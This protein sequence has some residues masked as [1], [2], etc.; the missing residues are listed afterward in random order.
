M[1]TEYKLSYTASEI[2]RKLA[3]VDETKSSLENDYYTSTEIDTKINEVNTSLEAKA[4]LVDGKIPTSQLPDDIGGDVAW[5][6]IQNKPFGEGGMVTVEF[7]S[8]ISESTV[9]SSQ[10]LEALGGLAFNYVKVGSQFDST[11]EI[12]GAPISATANGQTH[13]FTVDSSHL[14][15]IENGFAVI[16]MGESVF[17]PACLNVTS[18]GTLTLPLADAF[19]EDLVFNTTETGLYFVYIDG[20]GQ[21]N[22][23]AR[24]EVK[25]ID[26]KFIPDTIARKSDI[27]TIDLSGKADLVN[28]KVP[29]EQLPDDIGGGVSSWND[30][31]DKP[32]YEEGVSITVP[33]DVSGL[34][35][36]GSQ[37][38][39]ALGGTS[40]SFIKVNDALSTSEETYGALI[41]V[42]NDGGILEFIVDDSYVNN[43]DNGFALISFDN[44]FYPLA[45]NVN[46]VGTTVLSTADMLGEDM[47]FN[48]TETGFYVLYIEG[49]GNV[50]SYSNG[51]FKQLDEK[52]I[53][54]IFVKSA[55]MGT[56][57]GVATLD[58]DGKVP[59]SQLPDNIGSGS[60]GG[61]GVTSWNDLEDKPFGED[62]ITIELPTD[63]SESSTVSTQGLS[64]LGGIAFTY[65]KVRS[66]FNSADEVIG[67]EV[68]ATIS[69]APLDFAVD[70]SHIADADN[71]FAILYSD[72]DNG[73]ILPACINVTSVGVLTIPAVEIFGE[74]LIIDVTNEG[75]EGLYF[76][77]VEGMGQTNSI[78]ASTVNKIDIKYLPSNIGGG[79]TEVTWDDIKNKP[80]G[81]TGWSIEWDGNPDNSLGSYFLEAAGVT[82]Y[83][84]GNEAKTKEEVVGTTCKWVSDDAESECIITIDD[85]I[86]TDSENCFVLLSEDIGGLFAIVLA[87]GTYDFMGMSLV[88]STGVWAIK[89]DGYTSTYIGGSEIK[90]IDKKY[91]PDDI[92]ASVSLT[93]DEVPTEGSQNPV[94]SMGIYSAISALEGKITSTFCYKGTVDNYSDLPSSN[95]TVGDV[96]NIANADEANGVNAGD[97]A[98]W[99]GSSWDILAGVIDLSDYY[100]KTEI[101]SM[102][103]NGNINLTN[104]YTKAETDSL[105]ANAN[106]GAGGGGNVDLS[107]YYTK[108]ETD[109]SLALK[110][111]LVDGKVPLEQLPEDIGSGGNIVDC[112]TYS[113]GSFMSSDPIMI[114]NYHKV[115]NTITADYQIDWNI[116]VYDIDTN[117][118]LFTFTSP[119][120]ITSNDNIVINIAT[121]FNGTTYNDY[122]SDLS[123]ELQDTKGLKK[124]AWYT[125]YCVYNEIQGKMVGYLISASADVDTSALQTKAN[126]VTSINEN[127]TDEQ[128]PSAKLL[129]DIVGD[130][131]AVLDEISALIG[132]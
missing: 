11:E 110:A 31:T 105:I 32:F 67:A 64:A 38:L 128:Y 104:Y 50:I 92:V 52:F 111:D 124:N 68:S 71:G 19:G 78:T 85:I 90:Q 101:D 100:T 45:I 2:N 115:M 25:Q 23:I 18:V 66:P 74:D 34:P 30:L 22:S 87:D 14:M 73:I 129:Y 72:F 95:N 106:A 13:E 89:T 120:N 113:G 81:E 58:A 28:G 126:L 42:N 53:P 112:P 26:E 79:L 57:N 61:S 99:N 102:A 1:A 80:F 51:E 24:K 84:I 4:D 12:I 41:K 60:G 56:P 83:K 49:M 88:L 117:E 16:Y 132:E 114:F 33:S 130:C 125:V 103:L 6:D 5:E 98:A 3:T 17:L 39:E 21:T 8:D 86:D 35:M 75:S 107:D 94:K 36:I 54:D 91:I 118:F 59:T 108:S 109:S 44:G 48:V 123:V 55:K 63:V 46:T 93:F 65:V 20:M 97:N 77:C 122:T 7:P 69:G 70:T 127:S 119:G 116:G 131:N 10:P 37:P 15:D 27:P 29:A 47:T 43:L 40:F 76:I 62:S 9:I 96:W 121:G 82:F